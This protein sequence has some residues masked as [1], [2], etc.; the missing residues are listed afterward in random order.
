MKQGKTWYM[1]TIVLQC[2]QVVSMCLRLSLYVSGDHLN[3]SYICESYV[4]SDVT[5]LLT[6]STFHAS[7]GMF[8]LSIGLFM[9]KDVPLSVIG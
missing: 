3:V 9:S 5:E 7:P 8:S 6:D 4:Q 2:Y 1:I